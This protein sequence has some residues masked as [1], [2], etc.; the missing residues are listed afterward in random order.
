LRPIRSI[1]P[2]KLL[3]PVGVKEKSDKKKGQEKSDG[4]IFALN[5]LVFVKNT[6]AA[7]GQSVGGVS[8]SILGNVIHPALITPST[9]KLIT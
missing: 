1:A 8:S 7:H 6:N 2:G 4:F 5:P 9:K 3:W